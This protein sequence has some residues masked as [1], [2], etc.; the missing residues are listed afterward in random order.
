VEV[1]PESIVNSSQAAGLMLQGL[2]GPA[3]AMGAR[4]I[5]DAMSEYGIETTTDWQRAAALVVG[6]DRELSYER[7]TQASNA[8]R[9]GARFVATN[10]D[11]TFPIHGGFLPGGGAIVAAVEVATGVKPEVAGKPYPAMR[12]LLRS[13]GVGVAWVI[14]DRIDTDVALAAEEED[15]RS[16]L[17]GTGVTP[18]GT[19]S[20]ADHVAEDLSAAVDLVFQHLEEG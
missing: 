6:L 16:V 18:P 15:W 19:A 2:D 3:F 9:S 13:R 5:E 10:I 14:G 11:P 7:L 8:V 17:V 1:P 4:A 20:P 12:A